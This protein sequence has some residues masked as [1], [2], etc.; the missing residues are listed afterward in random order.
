MQH[1]STIET[2]EGM[3]NPQKENGYTGVANEIL[4]QIVQKP[5]NGTQFRIV[6]VVWRNTYGYHRKDHEM[7]IDYIAQATGIHATQVKREV[8]KLIDQN[9]ITVVREATK[10]RSRVIG[11]QKNYDLWF[12]GT[13]SLPQPDSWGNGFTPSEGT[14][15]PPR[16]GTNPP[17]NKERKENSKERNTSLPR[18][19]KTPYSEDSIPYRQAVYFHKKIMVHAAANK[20]DHLVK[21]APL[22]K[23]ADEFRKI[24]EI[25]KR[26]TKELLS[27]IDWCTSDTFWQVNILSA[28]KLR[29]KYVQLAV[30]MNASPAKRGGQSR[31]DR[32]KALLQKH[33]EEARHEQGG[34]S[35]ASLFGHYGLPDGGADE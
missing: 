30:K 14:D 26:D 17:P 35:E 29:E 20:V 33:M 32:N 4:D 2:G 27:I 23:W 6:I 7:S 8:K 21:D 28:K 13:D 16:E 11:F 15:S 18:N 3:A 24:V 25:D 9:V 10:N 22:Q 1:N 31:D 12:G 5:F 34:N 19:K